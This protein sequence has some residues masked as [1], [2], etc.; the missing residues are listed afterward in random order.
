[1]KKS[2]LW[3]VAGAFALV[4]PIILGLAWWLLLL[5]WVNAILFFAIAQQYKEQEKNQ[6]LRDSYINGRY[7][8]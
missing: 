2:S 7:N 1:M 5:F 6:A 4:A 3:G 8:K